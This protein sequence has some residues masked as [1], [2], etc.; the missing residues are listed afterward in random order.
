MSLLYSMNA[1]QGAA[2]V[3]AHAT[4][5]KMLISFTLRVYQYLEPDKKRKA[6]LEASPTLQE[7]QKAQMNESE[8]AALLTVILLFLSGVNGAEPSNAATLAVVGQVGYVWSR[9]V[10]GYPKLPTITFAVIRYG[11]LFLATAELVKLAF[12]AAE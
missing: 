2:I 7:F 4:F 10:I 5:T 12:P 11:G 3:A 8:Y 9:T 1:L 6:E